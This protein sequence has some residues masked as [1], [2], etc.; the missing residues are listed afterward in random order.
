[1]RAGAESPISEAEAAALF[2][3]L[4]RE[5]A[6]VLAVSGGPDS[7]A[8]M[9]LAAR[10][11]DGLKQSAEAD[12]RHDRSRPARGVCARGAGRETARPQAQGR[13]PH[14]ALDRPQAE[15]RHPGSRA[16][17]ALSPARRGGAAAPAREYILTAHTLDDQAETV[18]FRLARRQRGHRACAGWRARCRFPPAQCGKDRLFLVPPAACRAQIPPARDARGRRHSFRRRSLEPRSA[19]HPAAPARTDA[20]RSP[21]KG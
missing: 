5:P 1:M 12:R 13:A 16:R 4:A 11:R 2:G 18:L 6:L 20:A 8:L 9:W 14:A 15:D 21:P 17:R 7:T 10:W 3:L 19:L